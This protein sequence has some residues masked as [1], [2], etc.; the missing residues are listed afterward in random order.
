LEFSSKPFLM[1]ITCPSSCG[2]FH[3]QTQNILPMLRA[4]FSIKMNKLG[5]NS[6]FFNN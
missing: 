3:A 6:P 4:I 1:G 5:F 2:P